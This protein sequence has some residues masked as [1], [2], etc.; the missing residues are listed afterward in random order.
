FNVTN[1]YS[2]YSNYNRK[3]LELF[4]QI[5]NDRNINLYNEDF[6]DFV[7][8]IIKKLDPDTLIFYF[9]PPYLVS[10]S[11]YN[12]TWSITNENRLISI[13]KILDDKGIK[14]VASNFLK[15][16]NNINTVLKKFIEDRSI[17]VK[18]L[19]ISYKNSN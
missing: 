16:G 9:H 13:F 12:S 7:L 14:F 4:I 8:I 11:P 17:N 1:G 15:K 3:N 10:L 19:N 6:E 18:K 5:A 2:G